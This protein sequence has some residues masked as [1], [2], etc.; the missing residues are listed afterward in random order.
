MPMVHWPDG[1]WLT[2]ESWGKMLK[3][4]A[5]EQWT[6]MSGTRLR[7]EMARRARRWS[8][9]HIDTDGSCEEFFREMERAQMLVVAEPV[10]EHGS[11]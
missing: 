2:A 1:S 10:T 4:L 9:M 11:T 8:G 3:V 5:D 7:R 6:P